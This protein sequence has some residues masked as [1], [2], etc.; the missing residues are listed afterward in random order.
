MKNWD[1]H[2]EEMKTIEYAVDTQDVVEFFF[3]FIFRLSFNIV[4]QIFVGRAI[5]IFIELVVV[6]AQ[7]PK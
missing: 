7:A 4:C 1:N 6:K 5:Q 2:D 3:F